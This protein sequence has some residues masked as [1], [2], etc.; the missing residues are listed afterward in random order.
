MQRDLFSVVQILL[1]D[2]AERFEG[3]LGFVGGVEYSAVRI[4]VRCGV[5]ELVPQDD[6]HRV[7]GQ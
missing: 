3:R 2:L 7:L 6:L 1:A 4:V 5:G